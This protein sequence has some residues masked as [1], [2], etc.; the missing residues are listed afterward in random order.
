MAPVHNTHYDAGGPR[1]EQEEGADQKGARQHNTDGQQQPVAQADVLFPEQEG[2]AVGVRG[3]ALPTVVA[4]DS[5]HA[6]NGLH[7]LWCL[8]EPVEVEGELCVFNGL[9][10]WD[11]V[12]KKYEESQL[13]ESRSLIILKYTFFFFFRL[14][15][16]NNDDDHYIVSIGVF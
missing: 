5:P 13:V 8:P 4:A 12:E 7:K 9:S 6:L 11:C 10:G 16:A 2:V 1:I 15:T 3:Q 14:Y